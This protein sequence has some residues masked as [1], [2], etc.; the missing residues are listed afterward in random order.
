MAL[1]R[2]LTEAAEAVAERLVARKE[3]VAVAESSAGGLISAS[4]LSVAGASAYYAGGT[5]IYT[6]VGSR[7]LLAG[8][9]TLADDVR[10]ASEPF[11][12]FLAPA[13]AAKLGT[14]WGVGETGAAGPTGNRYGD[15]AGHAWIAVAGP[16][17]AVVT[18][19][20]LTGS[21]NRHD[22]MVAFA[23][24]ALGLLRRELD[25]VAHH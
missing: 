23:C 17:S 24:A 11:A 22:N 21:S 5:V 9:I 25:N 12:R 19:H 18:E 13:V 14:M 16:S 3:K 8:E 2:E 1:S 7:A 20:V 15:P 10:G 4:L 6:V